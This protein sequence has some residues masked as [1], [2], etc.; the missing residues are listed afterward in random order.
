MTH[1]AF[2]QW[3]QNAQR[4][5]QLRDKYRRLAG[6]I[7]HRDKLLV[8]NAWM[9]FVREQRAKRRA[10]A[11]FS[12]NIVTKCWLRWRKHHD[13]LVALRAVSG[14]VAARLRMMNA[15]KA[16]NTWYEFTQEQIEMRNRQ[17]RALAFFMNGTQVRVFAAW[18]AHTE[19]AKHCRE[20]V[21]AMLANAQLA[22]TFTVWV[23]H[24]REVQRAYRMATTLQACWRGVVIRRQLE[25]HYLYMVWAT[26]MIQNAWRGRLGRALLLAATRKARL[27]EYLRAERE[28]DAM[29]AE[30]AHTRQVER[31]LSMV[32][33]LQRRWRGVAARHLFEEVRRARF[34]LRKQQ[35]AEM[36]ELV[37][38]QARRRQLERERLERTKNLAAI[39]IQRHIRG[40]L[41]RRWFASQK[42]LLVK[43]RCASHV[44]AVYRG[45]I[46]RR[47]TAALRRSYISRMEV[48]TRRAV[49]GKMLRTLGA[50]TRPTQ[51]GLRSFLA[52]FGLDPATFLT[53]IRSVFR[54]V[55]EDFDELR[56]FFH[57]VKKKVDANAAKQIEAQAKV[58][59]AA[60]PTLV[61]EK[62]RRRT[63]GFM[64][65]Q[66]KSQAAQRFLGDFEQMVTSA[67]D[68]KRLDEERVDRGSAVRVV[69]PG[70]RA[71]ARLR[72]Y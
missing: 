17:R 8:W 3:H 61:P 21:R 55:R 64:R 45:R 67:A 63:F 65:L 22:F 50:P 52:F 37:R 53:D 28:R 68:E 25:N 32:I 18:A 9:D 40:Y 12:S 62:A 47:R 20:R 66:S 59:A 24:V 15:A 31:E 33:V 7:F 16:V 49:E 10:F 69:L 4:E 34:L 2:R 58:L 19:Y 14:R 1:W 23:T 11:K 46:A 70:H 36:Q 60:P 54:E 51:R 38:V 41:F 72:S 39:T 26:V 57:V 42:E 35:E 56:T 30:E 6:K 43:I 48:L 27:R 71:A 44:Q 5:R 29:A 13:D